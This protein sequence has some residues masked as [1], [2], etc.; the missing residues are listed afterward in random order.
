M[1]SPINLALWLREDYRAD[2]LALVDEVQ[3]QDAGLMTIKTVARRNWPEGSDAPYATWY[4]PH[5]RPDLIAATV[6][7]SLARPEV[8]GIATPGDVRLLKHVIA[9]EKE[10]M[11]IADAE[12][13]LATD[14]AYSSP[15]VAMPF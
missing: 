8:T 11:E 9:A 4:E 3:R 13:L 10:R 15:F 2:Y 7:W 1:L 5:D 12:A 14:P 6:S